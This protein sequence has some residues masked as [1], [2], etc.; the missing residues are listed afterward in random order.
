MGSALFK[1]FFSDYLKSYFVDMISVTSAGRY[2][3]SVTHYKSR[4]FMY[5]RG[6]VSRNLA[7]AVRIEICTK[8]DTVCK[9]KL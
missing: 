6:R 3:T 8:A 2:V 7:K 4:S 1:S 9:H 5:I